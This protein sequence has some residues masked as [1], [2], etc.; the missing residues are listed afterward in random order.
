M[1]FASRNSPRMAV[2]A[3]RPFISGICR[4]IIVTSGRCV[5]NCWI[6]SRPFEASATRVISG[7]SPSRTAMPSLMRTWSSTARTR[8]RA[9]PSLT[10]YGLLLIR[11]CRGT[12]PKVPERPRRFHIR[13]RSWNIELDFRAAIQFRPDSQ[14]AAYK[15]GS[16][17]HSRQAVVPFAAISVEHVGGNPFPVVANAQP[18]ILFVVADFNFHVS[19]RCVPE[20]IAQRLRHKPVDFVPQ[21]R[22]QIS[23]RTFHKH[24]KRSGGLVVWPSCEFFC[25]GFYGDREIVLFDSG[26]AQGPNRI[27]ALSDCLRRAIDSIFKHLTSLS[28]TLR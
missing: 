3:S 28:R 14:F 4:S 22:M 23:R 11:F 15:F 1:I 17:P 9:E 2:M 18:E 19:R 12:L 25:D 20:G 21:D 13:F 5:R 16:L 8:I 6:A 7:S 27:P 26:H 24:L 10:F